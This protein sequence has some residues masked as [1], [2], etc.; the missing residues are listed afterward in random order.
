LKL[1]RGVTGF[2]S[3]VRAPPLPA[4]DVRAF[5]GHC[6]AAARAAGGFVLGFEDPYRHTNNFA[7]GL[8]GLGDGPVA[9]LL[10]A[11]FPLVGFAHPPAVGE[12]ELRFADAPALVEAFRG[13]D[14][15]RVLD[16]AVLEGPLT[17]DVVADLDKGER[18]QFTY[19][20]PS[21]VG[22]VVFNSWD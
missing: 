1:P 11:H 12:L 5:R 19:W 8:L 15:Y 7:A 17:P 9:V 3:G 2:R 21:R 13:F 18:A 14:G 6:Y 20:R 4:T 10:N 16:R 22:D